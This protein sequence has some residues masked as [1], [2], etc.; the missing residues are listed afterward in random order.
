M[1]P[2]FPIV[3]HAQSTQMMSVASHEQAQI[4]SPHLLGP[5]SFR[6][7]DEVGWGVLAAG[8]TPVQVDQRSHPA[9]TTLLAVDFQRGYD[10]LLPHEGANIPYEAQRLE[11]SRSPVDCS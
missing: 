9:I 8:H 3:H 5:R 2:R 11:D 1:T 7:D 10:L 4:N 6:Q